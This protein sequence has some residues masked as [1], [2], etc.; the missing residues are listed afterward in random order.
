[1]KSLL[2]SIATC[3]VITANSQNIGSSCRTP[4]GESAKCIQMYK[5]NHL[6]ELFVLHNK[7]PEQ[8]KF[9]EQSQ[10][11]KDMYGQLAVCCGSRSAAREPINTPNIGSSCTTPK[12]ESAKCI[13]MYKCNHLVEL[14]V[15]HNKTA[16]QIKF[17]EQ[18]QCGKDIYGQLAVCCG[19]R[20]A[21]RDRVTR[22][23]G[24]SCTTPKGESA[25]CVQMYKCNH[26]VELFVL[27]NKTPEQIKFLEQSQ[28]GKDMY[29]QLAVCC[30]SRSIVR[31]S[32]IDN[33]DG[34][35][36]PNKLIP[37]R[38]ECGV[39]G[40][41]SIYL[42]PI[43]DVDEFPWIAVLQY[44]NSTGH[45]KLSCSGTLVSSRYILTAAHC[46]T[47]ELNKRIGH[48]VNVRLGEWNISNPYR[49][50]RS[51]GRAKICNDP[52]VN[53]GV[54]E[55]IVH[56]NFNNKDLKHDIAL[57]RLDHEVQFSDNYNDIKSKLTV[58]L[59]NHSKCKE[60]LNHIN[61]NI[62]LGDGQICTL[63]SEYAC[64]GNISDGRPLMGVIKND[65]RW[66]MAG[67][68][69]TTLNA[70]SPDIP[71]VYTNV[72]YYLDWINKNVRE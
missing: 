54:E 47:Y 14:F 43:A 53:I 19:S 26:L 11:G 30:G 22:S 4:K 28:C 29:G 27:P 49:D 55:I 16:E 12:G 8:I 5:C 9:L 35:F 64:Q 44:R 23:I 52:E 67:V 71:E 66:Y 39:Q 56:P 70:C 1:M 17:L 58:R 60:L 20:S 42:G 62:T 18:S 38:T 63:R 51:S 36:K 25:K 46:V 10:C 50:C 72:S 7:T 34:D 31:R 15:L 45:L 61:I 6:A 65:F 41:S 40:S 48:L 3:L 32:I 57:V 2:F 69:S 21:V 24:S 13:Q 59:I 37:N 33:I 68:L